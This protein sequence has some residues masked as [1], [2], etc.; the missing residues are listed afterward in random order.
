MELVT[1]MKSPRLDMINGALNNNNLPVFLL[2]LYPRGQMPSIEK[3]KEYQYPFAE[4]EMPLLDEFEQHRKQNY[5]NRPG[6]VR[7]HM[8]K[9]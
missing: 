7:Q 1:R 3:R 6:W 2:A 9:Y 4:D 5:I 8:K